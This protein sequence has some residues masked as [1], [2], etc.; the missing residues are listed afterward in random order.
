ME[1]DPASLDPEP[2]T[3]KFAA[4]ASAALGLMSLC[5]GIVPACGAPMSV[6]GIILGVLSLR[7]E[8]SKTAMTGIGISILGLLIT[9]VY[10][11]FLAFKN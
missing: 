7:F 6:L 5:G 10:M 4:L 8:R 1:T 11:V 9:I 3:A 2:R